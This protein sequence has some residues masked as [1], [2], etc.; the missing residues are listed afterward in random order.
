[1]ALF[2]ATP[3]T[4]TLP[5]V[6]WPQIRYL[7]TPVVAAAL[8]VTVALTVAVLAAASRLGGVRDL[9]AAR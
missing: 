1:M 3:R 6:I 8:S 7:L 5:M 4:R 2:L 9:L